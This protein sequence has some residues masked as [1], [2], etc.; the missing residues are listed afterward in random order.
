MNLGALTPAERAY[1]ERRMLETKL[2]FFI[3]YV[4]REHVAPLHLSPLMRVLEDAIIGKKPKRVLVSTPPRH[5]K[6]VTLCNAAAWKLF[7]EPH[8]RVGYASYGQPLARKMSKEIRAYCE[9]AGVMLDPKARANDHWYTKRGGSLLATGVGGALTGYGI[10]LMIVDDP[11]KN[12]EVAE[13]ILVREKVWDWFNDVVYT[14]LEPGASCVVVAT[15]WHP[16]DLIGRLSLQGGWEVINLPALSDDNVALWPQ[17]YSV[18][19]LED[20]RRQVGEYTW[21]SLYQGQPRPKGNKLFGDPLVYD[22]PETDG[23]RIVMSVDPAA[24]EKT[25]SDYSAIVVQAIRGRGPGMSSD[26]LDVK[27]VQL[28]IPKVAELIAQMAMS[29]NTKPV[30]ESHGTGKA[31]PAVLKSIRP[32]LAFFEVSPR[33]DKFTRAQP[34]SAAWNDNRVRVPKS[35]PW[36]RDFLNEV[37]GFTGVGDAHDD[38]VDALAYGWNSVAMVAPA[39]VRTSRPSDYLPFG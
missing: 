8:A 21:A 17:R 6:S 13:S 4:K 9:A 2:Q 10:D 30:I 19:A 39:A 27:R 31:I 1:L 12:R 34:V 18:E 16:D 22:R 24:S 26:I 38:Q 29:Y 11:I 37:T 32:E 25:S 36:V 5:G 14:R 23:A 15:R 33:G 3:P 20:L 28:P 35:A 7:L